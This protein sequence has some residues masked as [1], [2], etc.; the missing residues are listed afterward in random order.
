MGDA[1]AFGLGLP[2]FARMADPIKQRIV[3]AASVAFGGKSG[4]QLRPRFTMPVLPGIVQRTLVMR[5]G[6]RG[7]Y[8]EGQFG[9][10]GYFPNRWRHYSR[11]SI[12]RTLG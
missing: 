5:A 10:A 1:V 3:I 11:A 6:R 4:Q 9:L 7:H 8:N 2:P 12:R